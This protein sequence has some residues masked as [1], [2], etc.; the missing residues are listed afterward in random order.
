MEV[1][2]VVLRVF[3]V[4]ARDVPRREHL[5]GR[6]IG[7]IQ[8]VPLRAMDDNRSA[9]VFGERQR[10]RDGFTA[11]V[12]AVQRQRRRTGGE[13]D[14][15][16]VPTAVLDHRRPTAASRHM[17]PRS[18]AVS[19]FGRRPLLP[20]PGHVPHLAGRRRPPSQPSVLGQHQ[21]RRPRVTEGRRQR[22]HIHDRP[23]HVGNCH[24]HRARR[25]L[26][27]PGAFV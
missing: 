11:V 18:N 13:I 23:Q 19:V 15:G 6:E 16:A 3:L 12:P 8:P 27:P 25:H 7:D 24:V 21:P 2:E 20:V 1:V 9:G 22:C 5:A 4:P 26:G 17:E 14:D 10:E